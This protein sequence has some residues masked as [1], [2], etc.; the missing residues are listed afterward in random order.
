MAGR[1]RHDQ[2]EDMERQYEIIYDK[3]PSAPAD[4]RYTSNNDK[5]ECP[6][7]GEHSE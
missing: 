3:A 2:D 5:D 1:F 4:N 6:D 7:G